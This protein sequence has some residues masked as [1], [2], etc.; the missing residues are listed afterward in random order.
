MTLMRKKNLPWKNNYKFFLYIIYRIRFVYEK[1]V[2][3]KEKYN[4][5]KKI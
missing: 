5:S 2:Y 4:N 3:I 1:I